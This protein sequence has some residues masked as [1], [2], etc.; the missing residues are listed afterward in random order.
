MDPETA[1]KQ[2]ED[3]KKEL[4]AAYRHMSAAVLGLPVPM[5]LPA[6]Q[7]DQPLVLRSLDL[8]WDLTEGS[9]DPQDV[10]RVREM[11]TAW[12]TAYELG[13][14]AAGSGPAP[15]RL[16]GMAAALATCRENARQVIASRNRLAALRAK[17]AREEAKRRKEDS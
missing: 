6:W 9:A 13:I 11:L 4:D 2:F 8:A 16:R 17:I 3:L 5:R 7:D 14:V 12:A 1:A 15:W 10:T